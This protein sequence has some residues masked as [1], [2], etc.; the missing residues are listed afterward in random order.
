MELLVQLH[1]H[2]IH[3][4]GII[5]PW[6][7]PL[8]NAISHIAT[9]LFTGNAAIVKVS[10]WASWSVHY[11]DNMFKELLRVRTFLF[12]KLIFQATGHSTDLVQFVTGYAGI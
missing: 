3:S 2:S 1:I 7:F 4:K 9:A 6:N 12:R 10:E 8:H 11:L 5:I